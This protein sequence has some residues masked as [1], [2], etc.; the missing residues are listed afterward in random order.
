MGKKDEELETSSEAA[1][2]TFDVEEL[3]FADLEDFEEVTG[4]D[5]L[6]VVEK[7]STSAKVLAGL[8][9]IARRRTEPGLTFD[10]VRGMRVTEL[11]T[12]FPKA[13]EA[14]A[15]SS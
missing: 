12:V 3:T 2:V 9:W 4:A 1:A 13:A 10:T 5:L 11:A 15:P 8:L 14:A 6:Q 7:G